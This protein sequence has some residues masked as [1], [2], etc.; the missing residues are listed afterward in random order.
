M[1]SGE[2]FLKANQSEMVHISNRILPHNVLMC[3]VFGDVN[4]NWTGLI[5]FPKSYSNFIGFF[6]FLFAC[7]FVFEEM[8]VCRRR[9]DW[10]YFK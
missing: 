8:D 10:I 4:S 6:F 3:A 7:L 5:L 9:V 2:N 1:G